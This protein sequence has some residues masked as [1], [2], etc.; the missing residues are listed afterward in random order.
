MS[1][2]KSP[3]LGRRQLLT[4]LLVGVALTPI[5]FLSS[6]RARAEELPLVDPS[7]AAAKKLGYVPDAAKAKAA[8]KGS[9]CGNCAM[10]QG[11]YGSKQGECHLF[12]G[13][14]VLATGW[15]RSWE[16]QM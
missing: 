4:R 1:L 2:T 9:H 16:A 6:R 12:P 14:D 8:A 11:A 3:D 10:Y 15:C 7:S 13:K 5:A